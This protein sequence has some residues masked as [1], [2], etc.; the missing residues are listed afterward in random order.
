MLDKKILDALYNNYI[1]FLFFR[2]HVR[3][4]NV[5]VNENPILINIYDIN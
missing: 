3:S 1:T 5:K 4:V 2:L